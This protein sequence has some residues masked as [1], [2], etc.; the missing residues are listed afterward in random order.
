MYEAQADTIDVDDI[1]KNM[2]NRI[3]LR[4]L[5]RNDTA[6]E[7]YKSLCIQNHDNAHAYVPEG[8]YDMGWL[9]YFIGKNQ[10]LEDLYIHIVAF[11]PI[12]VASV[13]DVM[14]P[15]LRGISHNKSI[16]DIHFANVDLLG[17]DMFTMMGTF[18]QN[19]H[20]LTDININH[21][22]WGDEGGRLFALALGNC[23]NKSLQKLNLQN[24]NITEE[25]MVDIITSLSMHPHMKFLYLDGNCLRK[26]GCMALATLVQCSSTKLHNLY[27]SNNDIGDDG[28]EALVP[29]LANCNHLKE[30]QLFNNPSITTRGRQSL[31]T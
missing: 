20:C 27:L 4:R 6:D 25:G 23:T 13:R 2:N 3:I 22:A 8:A 21:C 18:F 14:E 7:N 30:L 12:S 29:A 1:A 9:G 31:A 17:G 10:H 16:R 24:N 15:F 26:N 19:N 5:Q 28:I 11:T